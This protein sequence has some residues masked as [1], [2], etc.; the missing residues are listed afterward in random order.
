MDCAASS[1]SNIKQ[2]PKFRRRG[3]VKDF[4]IW[5]AWGVEHLEFAKARGG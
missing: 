3:E 5:R 1:T 2:N 4:G